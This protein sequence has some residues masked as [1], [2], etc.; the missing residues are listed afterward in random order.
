MRS[1]V[2]CVFYSRFEL[3]AALGDRRALLSEPVALA[4]EAGREQVVGEVS[5][6]AEAFGVVRGM[7]LG[8][9][10]SRCPALGLI[11]PDP[12]GV[13]SLWNG[14]LDRLEA[15]GAEVESDR[16]GAAFF[17]SAG[18]HGLHG[19]GLAGVLA[20][21][22]RVLG[23]GARFGVAPSRFAAHAAALKVRPRRGRRA[24]VVEESGVRDFLAPL[25][26]TLLRGRPELQA[27]PEIFERLG[28]RTLGEV[29]ELPSRALA[30][31]FGHPGLLAHDLARGS[32]FPLDPRRPP[33][34][35][36]ERLDLPEAA[37]GQQLER[38]LELLVAR[39]LARRE[40]RGRT[41]R[42]LAVSA[43]FV[44][45]GTWRVAIALRHPSA[46]AERI[47]L[48]L[49]PKLAELPAPAE[50]LALEVEAFGPPAHDQ[51]RLLD[52]GAAV[53]RGRLGEA[54][55]QARQAAG[56]E[57]ALKVLEVDPQSRIPE[58]RAVL[59]P[60]PDT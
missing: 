30:E 38:A 51:G 12:E 35:V 21:A 16:A 22:R 7:R 45:G 9:A 58:R 3:L 23:P 33:E 39:V 28:I 41:L 54:V 56:S 29:A 27:L 44:A 19:G 60:F 40:R 18:L 53:R 1:M 14:V 47:Q 46:D 57:A 37:S 10:M 20:E 31:R 49:A 17:E 24:F 43:R 2:V 26:V 42:G 50:S 25:P 8:E 6:A 52:E 34:P 13:R 15:I 36:S 11:P 48:A 59:A 32:D 55:R 5:A 4:P